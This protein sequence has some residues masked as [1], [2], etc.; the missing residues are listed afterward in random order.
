MPKPRVNGKPKINY[1]SLPAMAPGYGKNPLACENPSQ[2]L[3]LLRPEA[4]NSSIILPFSGEEASTTFV[5]VTTTRP[6][7]C[8]FAKII[9]FI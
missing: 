9:Y 1:S 4:D 3:E 2:G 5:I 7:M 8:I 6:L